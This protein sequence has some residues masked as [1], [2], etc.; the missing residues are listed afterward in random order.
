MFILF[1]SETTHL[2]Y[3]FDIFV[4]SL[5]HV[6]PFKATFFH[7]KTIQRS[8]LGVRPFPTD[9]PCHRRW[10]QLQKSPKSGGG[11]GSHMGKTH[12]FASMWMW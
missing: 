3:M 2:W 5:N 8:A 12:G 1:N 11:G 10:S 7:Q 9:G 4:I 6:K